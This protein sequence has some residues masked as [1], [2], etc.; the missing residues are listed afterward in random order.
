VNRLSPTKWSL[1][2][3]P[4][5]RFSRGTVLAVCLLISACSKPADPVVL[6]VEKP[7]PVV[8]DPAQLLLEAQPH[9]PPAS[10]EPD[11]FAAEAREKAIRQTA[12]A[13]EEECRKAAGGDWDLWE[14]DTAIYRAAL[15]AK[16]DALKDFDHPRGVLIEAN[17]EPLEGRD[18]FP[19]FEVAPRAHLEYL[20]NST[21]LDAFRKSRI[22]VDAHRWLRARGIDLI[23]VPAPKM[24]EVYIEHFLDPCPADGIIAPHV[25]H[26]LLELLNEDVE[27]VDGL[28]LFRSIR[29]A[30]REYL[31][32]TADMH[33]GFRGIRI[34]AKEVADR[35]ARYKFGARARYGLPIVKAAPEN[36]SIAGTSDNDLCLA[37]PGWAALTDEQRARARTAQSATFCQVTTWNGQAPP[38]DPESPVV[39]IGNSFAQHFRE[40]FVR[41]ANL[42][43]KT[44]WRAGGTTE[45]FVDFLREPDLLKNCKVVVWVTSNRHLQGLRPL[46]EKITAEVRA[47]AKAH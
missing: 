37:A 13:I 9:R 23:F 31:Y 10:G 29:D 34:M 16:I 11:P 26:T 15:K 47:S 40:Q 24:T 45:A 7:A 38:D 22:V 14:R 42:L 41:E 33:W 18:K 20:Y 32:N 12:G 25:R 21:G 8:A 4:L 27:V 1:D 3:H 30:D 43:V 2:R 35:I 19:L 36:C 6:V 44:R 46:P 39:V 17:S 28:P 5:L